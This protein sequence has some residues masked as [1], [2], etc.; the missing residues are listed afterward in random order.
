MCVCVCVCSGKSEF[1]SERNEKFE[2]R[3]V[4]LR[5]DCQ[6]GGACVGRLW[7]GARQIVTDKHR[8][9]K[10][11]R[12]VQRLRVRLD[13]HLILDEQ[14]FE[15]LGVKL[16]ISEQALDSVYDEPMSMEGEDIV[17]ALQAAPNVA[18]D[19]NM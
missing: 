3:E 2:I 4:A 6:A 9:I 17:K 18:A 16:C 15:R 1:P 8:S 12:L 11:T 13:L 10:A 14:V 5:V 7:S 19:D